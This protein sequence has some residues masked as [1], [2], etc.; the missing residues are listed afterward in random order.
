MAGKACGEREK[1][2]KEYGHQAEAVDAIQSV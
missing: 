1:H 2:E